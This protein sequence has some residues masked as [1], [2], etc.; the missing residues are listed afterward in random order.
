MKKRETFK[1]KHKEPFAVEC[2]G[3]TV[4]EIPPLDRLAYEDWADISQLGDDADT[5]MVID[6]YRAFFLRVCPDLEGEDIGDNQ[7]VILGRGYLEA[8]GE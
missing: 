3:G 5:K 1:L 7:W 2:D 4:Y 6:T 8:M